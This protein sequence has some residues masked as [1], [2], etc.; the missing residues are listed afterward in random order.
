MIDNT[1]EF[2]RMSFM[3][4]FSEYNQIKMFPEDEKHTSFRTPF[5]VY[6]YTVIPFCQKNTGATYQRAIMKIFQDIQHKTIKCY[7]EDLAVK[8]K[9]K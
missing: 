1:C 3:D 8:S 6:Y 2:E 7:V 4:D 9:H 5:I